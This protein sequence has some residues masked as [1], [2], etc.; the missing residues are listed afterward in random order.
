M[1]KMK[2]LTMESLTGVEKWIDVLE[3]RLPRDFTT[4][5]DVVVVN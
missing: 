3:E 2:D 4:K 1:L 5:A